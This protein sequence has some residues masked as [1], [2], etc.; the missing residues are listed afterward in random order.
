MQDVV[1]S[2][3]GVIDLDPDALNT[4]YL[5]ER[6]KRLRDHANNQ[7]VEVDAGFSNSVVPAAYAQTGPGQLL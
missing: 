2:T 4:T 5:E 3:L 6:G 7:Y 1:N